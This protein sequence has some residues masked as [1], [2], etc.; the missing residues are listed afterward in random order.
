M[1]SLS[2]H[3]KQ[4][5]LR[6]LNQQ[7]QVKRIFDDFTR[8]SGLILTQWTEKN[9]DNVWI[10]NATLEKQIDNLLKDLHSDLLTNI[11][12]NTTGAWEASNLKNDDLLKAFIK[13][14]ALP[15]LIGQSKYEKLEKG[16]F[17]SNI[18]A[19]KA[20]Q[21]RQIDGSTVSD[22]VWNAVDGAKQNLEYYL[23]SGI[24]T[25]RPAAI[26]SQDIRQLLQDPDKRFRRIKDEDGNLTLSKPMQ[27]YHPGQG[28]YRSS[29]MNA[30]RVAVTETNQAYHTA[31]HERWKNQGFVLGIEVH[32]SKSNKGP[33]AICDPMVGKYPPNYK[34]IGNHP[35]CICFA[36]PIMLEGE[37][38]TDYLLTGEVPQ[39]KIITTVPQSAF[40]FINEKE[41]NKNQWFVKENQE[42]FLKSE[43]SHSKEYVF[44]PKSLKQEGFHIKDNVESE[45]DKVIKGFNMEEFN[46]DLMQISDKYGLGIRSKHLN[47]YKDEIEFWCTGDND[48]SLKRFFQKD[49]VFHD[50]LKLPE[51]LQGKG[52]SKELLQAMYKQYQNA[53][54]KEIR[55]Q[56][57][58]DVGGYAWAKYG[59]SAKASEYNDITHWAHV[60]HNNQRI[61]K[62]DFNDFNK[63]IEQYK[64][65]NIP[66]HEL[67]SKPYGKKILLSSDW[68]GTIDLTDAK[69]K[70]VFEKYLFR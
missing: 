43:S 14:L 34:F 52:V 1:S 28:R 17:A 62:T 3:D 9:T 35:F 70:E 5:V 11:N 8:R 46:N 16:M 61:T 54:I 56:A 47:A 40:D 24:S 69:Q 55:I 66:M 32:R 38:F 22:K 63:W 41:A 10:R 65:A 36:V 49:V 48:F 19:L 7:G 50:T 6:L 21:Q 67:A 33:C 37:E 23:S 64:G 20:F 68:S 27:D 18:D 12:N 57:N 29:Y 60:M 58:M 30:L 53:G 4:H 44:N 25:G 51:D 42:Y 59:F 31:D 13:D 26:I 39:D 2:F 15:E 45:Y